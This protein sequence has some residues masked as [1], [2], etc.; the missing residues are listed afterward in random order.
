MSQAAKQLRG[1]SQ[2]EIKLW[3]FDIPHIDAHRTVRIYVPKDYAQ[4]RWHPVLYMFD[5]QNVFDDGP[6][7]AGGWHLH[8]TIERIARKKSPTPIIVGI[9]HGGAKR[10]DELSPFPGERSRGQADALLDW[11]VGGLIPSIAR[12]FRVINEPRGRI[13]GGSSL[14]GLAA[15]YA[16]FRRPEAF[17]GAM[18][19]SPSFWL[20]GGRILDFVA[21]QSNP[22]T[23]KVYLDCGAKEGGGRML[24][25]VEKAAAQLRARGYGDD[26][27][28]WRPDA[29]G[30]HNEKHWR[31]RAP[32][33]LRWLL[34]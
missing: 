29:R 34:R 5:G 14:G 9:D 28:L 10:I 3:H 2:G 16:H 21:S 15:Y 30:T 18:C 19:M 7:F 22:W 8:Q 1:N 32:K 11:M 6:S 13:V 27:V 25:L 12:E 17:G 23:S 4:G 26:K 31:R 33:A 24:S 20:G